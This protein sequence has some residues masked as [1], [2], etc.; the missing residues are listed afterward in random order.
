[1]TFVTRGAAAPQDFGQ[2]QPHG[3]HPSPRLPPWAA[4]T[5]L[6]DSTRAGDA[7]R[8]SFIL[9]GAAM[10]D[11]CWEQRGDLRSQTLRRR[12]SR[13]HP[14]TQAFLTATSFPAEL[15]QPLHDVQKG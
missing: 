14:C 5:P 2:S 1:M 10:F 6:L 12:Q 4:V 15:Q 8:P 9:W 13:F 11:Q 7:A 3:R